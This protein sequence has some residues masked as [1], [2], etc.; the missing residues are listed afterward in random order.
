MFCNQRVLRLL[1]YLIG[2][3]SGL[4]L[5]RLSERCDKIIMIEQKVSPKM[6]TKLFSMN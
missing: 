4:R 3:V 2:P 1:Q 5:A 6:Y